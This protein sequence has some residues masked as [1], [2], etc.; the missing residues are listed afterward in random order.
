[1]AKFKIENVVASTSLAAELD[2]KRFSGPREGRVRARAVPRPRVPDRR[3]EG[4]RPPVREREARLH[5]RAQALGRRAGREEDHGRAEGRRTPA[6]IHEAGVGT[7]VVASRRGACDA[8][9]RHGAATPQVWRKWLREDGLQIQDRVVASH[10]SDGAVRVLSSRGFPPQALGRWITN[11]P[12]TRKLQARV[13]PGF[14]KSAP[15]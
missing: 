12:G 2:L 8:P 5:G 6:L 1:M 15:W 3:A 7:R 14:P 13:E 4:R 9:M 10:G 11:R